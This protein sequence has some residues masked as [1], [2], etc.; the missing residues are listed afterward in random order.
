M[1]DSIARLWLSRCLYQSNPLPSTAVSCR[2][3]ELQL[4]FRSVGKRIEDQFEVAERMF[5]VLTA[6]PRKSPPAP[7]SDPL[8]AATISRHL[9][10]V[11]A[12]TEQPHRPVSM[13]FGFF[14]VGDSHVSG[15]DGRIGAF[16]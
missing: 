15:R 14:I 16:E 11:L 7:T 12:A 10:R 2:S 5:A 8:G 1:V 4:G 9:R 3:N 6:F 13:P